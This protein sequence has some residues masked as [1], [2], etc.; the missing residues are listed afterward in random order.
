MYF[1]AII[2]MPLGTHVVLT[3]LLLLVVQYTSSQL[4]AASSSLTQCVVGANDIAYGQC[5]E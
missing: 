4:Y 3:I 5:M 1:Y 2:L